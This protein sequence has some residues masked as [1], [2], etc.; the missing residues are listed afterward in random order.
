ME[1]EKIKPYMLQ[2][3]KILIAR[4]FFNERQAMKKNN[5]KK[6][7]FL[8][9]YNII[10]SAI[11][12]F[13]IFKVFAQQK[14]STELS[15]VCEVCATQNSKPIFEIAELSTVIFYSTNKNLILQSKWKNLK[16][17]PNR[18]NNITLPNFSKG[19]GFVLARNFAKI[20][21]A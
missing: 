6:P 4:V 16:S 13:T 7:N 17:T 9:I 20:F 18:R 10:L 11:L 5:S 8:L 21:C 14:K 12:L 1:I 2:S 3:T 15:K 19:R